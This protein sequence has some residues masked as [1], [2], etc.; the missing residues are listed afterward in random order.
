MFSYRAIYALLV[1][2]WIELELHFERRQNTG[3]SP[4]GLTKVKVVKDALRELWPPS[5]VH[6]AAHSDSLSALP[7]FS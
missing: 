6:Y 5:Q 7:V 2:A 1:H 4:S 3:R